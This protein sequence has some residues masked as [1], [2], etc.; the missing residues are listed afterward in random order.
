MVREARA[1]IAAGRGRA[2]A[3]D[4]RHLPA[5]LAVEARTTNWRVDAAAWRRLPCVR[6][7]RLALVRPGRVRDRRSDRPADR[8]SMLTAFDRRPASPASAA[9][10]TED[11]ALVMFRT[12][13]ALRVGGGQPGLARPQ[14]PAVV[15]VRRCRGHLALRPGAP[16]HPL[17]RRPRRTTSSL[18]RGAGAPRTPPRRYVDA[19]ARSPA[20]L[21]G[22]LRR[23]RRRHLSRH[24]RGA[25]RR[26]GLPTFADGAASGASPTPCGRRR[27]A[28]QL[29]PAVA[30]RPAH[31]ARVPHRL[32]APAAA[33]PR[34]ARG[35]PSTASRRS[36]WRRGPTSATARSPPPTSTSTAS[37][38]GRPTASRA[39]VRPRTA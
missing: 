12:D 36:R 32:P 37:A 38:T 3:A 31:E 7:H 30:R 8:P 10:G 26:D 4:P 2:A 18:M 14:E 24:R 25:R 19:A 16:R 28:T 34:S 11:V 33:S 1:R 13:R 27:P 29:G 21:P 39:A 6:R 23:L 5:G 20:G 17:G 22:L 9:V 35:P 15:R